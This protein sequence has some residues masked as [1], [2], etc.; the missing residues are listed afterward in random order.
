MDLPHTTASPAQEATVG[1][2]LQEIT[3]VGNRLEGMDSAI[4]LLAAE[5]KSIRLDIAG[6]QIRVSGLEQQEATMEN[7]LNTTPDRDQELLYLCSKLIDLED[8]SHRDNF[9]FSDSQ[10]K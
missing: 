4:P 8:W 3:A 2:I 5:M 1:R 7:H 9:V 6:F 10:N